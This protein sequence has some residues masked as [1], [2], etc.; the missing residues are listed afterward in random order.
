MGFSES[1]TI[2]EVSEAM[3]TTSVK[4]NPCSEIRVSTQQT[5]KSSSAVSYG[6][7]VKVA[8]KQA[9]LAQLSDQSEFERNRVASKED[10]TSTT[11]GENVDANSQSVFEST[12]QKFAAFD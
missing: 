9:G 5:A 4:P 6:G 1:S 7:Q 10:A 8:N 2:D 3:V 11:E 12:L